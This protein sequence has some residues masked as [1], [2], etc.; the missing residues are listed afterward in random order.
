M[1]WS[2][3]VGGG[4]EMISVLDLNTEF[5]KLTM[6]ERRT[7]TTTQS[8]RQGSRSRPA[9]YRDGVI[10]TFKF[11]GKS[12]WERHTQGE[13]IAQ[14][15]EGA[16]TLHL[17]TDEGHEAV[18]LEAGMMAIIPKNAWHHFVSP[19]GV[20]IMTVTPHPTDHLTVDVEDPRTI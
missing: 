17:M 15:V 8:E 18:D 20:A 11:S 1:F 12:A 9:S 6:F 2:Q 14:I 19:D 3:N 13:E 7:P 4:E 16:A 5:D 10:A